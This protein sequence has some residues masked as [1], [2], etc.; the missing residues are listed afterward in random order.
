M[1]EMPPRANTSQHKLFVF[2]LGDRL[3]ALRLE[4]IREI[5]AIAQLS[6]PP[7]LPPILEGFLNLGGVAIPVVAIK[8]LF[9]LG[10]HAW[11]PYA[12]LLILGTQSK[13]FAFLVDY[14]NGIV[15]V[16]IDSLLPVAADRSFND[17][18]EAEVAFDGR[19]LHLLA[20]ERLIL[21]EERARIAELQA[22]AEVRLGMLQERAP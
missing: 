13:P 10:D 3:C 18:V 15:D 1:D 12:H 21:Q 17:C 8:R 16:P 22:A 19:T 20:P 6:R 14:V 11:G 9:Q 7:G 2:A 5:V 4:A